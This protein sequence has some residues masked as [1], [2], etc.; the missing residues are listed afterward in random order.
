[1]IKYFSIAIILVSIISCVTPQQIQKPV[2][3]NPEEK[4]E[5]DENESIATVLSKLN[6]IDYKTFSGKTEVD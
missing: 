6:K 5:I 1:M 4:V 2:V 3:V